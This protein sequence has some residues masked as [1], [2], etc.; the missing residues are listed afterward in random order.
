VLILS[1]PP[2]HRSGEIDELEFRMAMI[3]LGVELSDMECDAVF[4]VFDQDGH[5]S[6]P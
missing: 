1:C 3:D 4:R 5:K 6:R 2:T